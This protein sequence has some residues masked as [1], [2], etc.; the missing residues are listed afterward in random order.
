MEFA[1]LLR[2]RRREPALRGSFRVPLGVA[3]LALLAALPVLL[4]ASGVALELQSREIG[5]PGVLV[6]LGLAMVGPLGYVLAAPARALAASPNSVQGS[7]S[8]RN[9]PDRTSEGGEQS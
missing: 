6:A 4:L 7:P 8:R 3:G 1:A 2:L 5:L 9:V